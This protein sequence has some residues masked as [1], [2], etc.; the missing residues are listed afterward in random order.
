[1][2][3]S[4]HDISHYMQVYESY[5][6][7]FH[8]IG[9]IDNE[10]PFHFTPPKNSL[11]SK[12]ALF[13]NINNIWSCIFVDHFNKKTFLLTPFLSNDLPPKISDITKTISKCFFCDHNKDL[14]YI[15]NTNDSLLTFHY[16][17]HKF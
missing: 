8:F 6:P 7:S 11:I 1:M 3:L 9:L 15:I 17:V 4:A 10:H 14:F 5:F 12:L 16:F 13:I 2:F